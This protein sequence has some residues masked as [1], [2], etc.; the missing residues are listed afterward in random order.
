MTRPTDSRLRAELQRLYLLPGSA[1]PADPAAPLDGIHPAGA[2]NP[3]QKHQGAE[4]S[5]PRLLDGQGRTRALVLE[6]AAPADWERLGAVWRGV[7]ADWGWPA[8]A[9]AA[10]GSDGLQLWF[11][12]AEPV[13]PAQAQALLH[14]L[15]QRHLH[16]LPPARVRCWPQPGAPAQ[17]SA[18]AD[19]GPSGLRHAPLVPP[20][21]AGAERWSAFVAPDLAPLFAETPFLDIPPGDDGQA[22]LLAGLRSLTPAQLA[23]RLAAHG[24]QPATATPTASAVA[25]A[26]EA[27][28]ADAALHGQRWV[29]PQD[30][31]RAV[32]N[33]AAVPMALRIE[34]AKA[35]MGV[36]PQR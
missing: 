19:G 24:A 36:Q 31:L 10:S 12:L 6:V 29:D 18:G 7:Q 30:F 5:T 17:A 3:A 25:T 22:T 32:M 26:A 11:S 9:I 35:L 27:P 21:I 1:D 34:A 14:Q 20:A 2:A 13:A 33:D 23:E 15:R 8:P 16:D 28:A 4:E